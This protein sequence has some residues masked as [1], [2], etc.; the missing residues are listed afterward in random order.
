MKR[1]ILLTSPLLLLLPA[2]A[3]EKRGENFV[4]GGRNWS[5]TLDARGSILS[6]HGASSKA[7]LWK[8]G[9]A[10]LWSARLRDASVVR[11][12][13]AAEVTSSLTADHKTLTLKY[14]QPALDVEVTATERADG[15]DWRA[16]VSP[17]TQAL[18]EFAL[19]ARLRFDSESMLRLVTPAQ[20][21]EA[22]GLA[23]KP[24]FFMRQSAS[25]AAGW[26][27][28]TAGP[29]AY[30]AILGAPPVQRDLAEAA[31]ALS[32]APAASQWLSPDAAQ[33]LAGKTARVVR[34]M[35]RA[36]ADVVLIDSANG[37]YLSGSK[38]G[39]SGGLLW[40][41]G[42]TVETADEW[43]APIIAGLIA[44]IAGNATASTS[45][46][47][48]PRIAMLSLRRGPQRG[49]F[50]GVS[51]DQWRAQLRAISSV[52]LEE[53]AD[54][55]SL[56]RA[57]S[58]HQYAAI[59]NPYGEAI[60]TGDNQTPLDVATQIAAWV[61]GGGHWIET[62]GFS[63]FK[64]L[65]P[66]KYFS[67]SAPYPG[68]FA[69]FF[70]LDGNGSSGALYSVQPQRET[71]WKAL[72]NPALALVP[73]RWSTGG[74]DAGAYLE[75]AWTP[76]VEPGTSWT[77]PISRL[78][79]GGS[80]LENA[81]R[82]ALDNQITRTLSDKMAPALLERFKRAVLVYYAG[83]A[84]S[85]IA[86]LKYLPPGCALHFA[87]YLHGGF[88]KQLPDHLPPNAGFGTSEQLAQF[89][90]QARRSG[91][92][93]EPYT[94]PTWWCDHPPGPTFLREGRAPLQ[95]NEDKSNTHE[96][97]SQND[98]WSI[99]LWHPSV[100]AAN[101]VIR[102]QFTQEFPVDV[103]FQDQVGARSPRLDFNP[104]SPS[105]HAYM[106]GLLAQAQEDSQVVPLSTENG[107]DH[108]VNWESQMCGFTFGTVPTEDAPA[109]STLLRDRFAPD[110][111]EVFPL[112]QAMA[113]DKV[114]FIHHDLGQFVTNREVLAW[115]LALGF[116]MSLRTDAGALGSDGPREWLKYLDRV[117]KSVCARMMGAP[118]QSWEYLNRDTIAS[119]FGD[120]SVQ[121]AL[122]PGAISWSAR[123][124]QVLA[125][126]D[127]KSA[128][129]IAQRRADGKFDVWFYGA[130]QSSARLQ[131]P[132][133]VG[134]S[135]LRWD[136]EKSSAALK[137][138]AVALTLP[139][140][141]NGRVQPPRELNMAPKQW[142][143]KPKIGLIEMAG[144][145]TPWSEITPAQWKS[146]LDQSRLAKQFGL[147]VE[148]LST[149]AQVLEALAG[150][151]A[152]YFAI[153]NPHTE[154]FPE[155]GRDRWREML[156]SIKSYVEHGGQWWATGGYSFFSAAWLE[157]GKWQQQDVG[158]SGLSTFGIP[159][160][161]GG[162]EDAPQPLRVE[163]EGS[164]WL[165]KGLQAKIAGGTSVINRGL[166]RSSEEA[167]HIALVGGA[168]GD[169]IGAYRL[170]GWGGLWRIGGFHPNPELAPQVVTEALEYQWTHAPE[171]VKISTKYLWHAVVEA[172]GVAKAR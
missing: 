62:G 24:A 82:H 115:T 9:A 29:S 151:P 70:H 57:L 87:D 59:L 120:V 148:V 116:N 128:P 67:Y 109:W 131:L 36:Q 147:Q 23:L 66:V 98:G 119:R 11:A 53:I 127:G 69:H 154:I 14:L 112:A 172:Q 97:Y 110:T 79:F 6:S 162:I 125:L 77:A 165:S 95:V 15:V 96:S 167:G 33:V 152:K 135:S 8:S 138:G 40:R 113:H 132:A 21:H 5:L 168:S 78:L 50:A 122:K 126:D 65:R 16:Q 55:P 7:T 88:D 121:A 39:G 86:N 12:V 42:G 32:L 41:I 81:R 73:S 60:P 139:T 118:L 117:Q 142:K 34:P 71:G 91:Q 129:S 153:V 61:R 18:T 133:S 141:A 19:P 130:P 30:S 144:L 45:A 35:T 68:S 140:R 47:G 2:R 52:K 49:D 107:W 146:A 136:E 75:A 54:L 103:L 105:P 102:D 10:G 20:V 44:K 84:G 58:S 63:F 94:N 171:P 114:A 43:N 169:W 108:L 28:E 46:G 90:A 143:A 158:D 38:L 1:L 163:G 99:T 92:L 89:F 51:V 155:A 111:F 76:W 72:Q 170:N 22:P 106:A 85:K 159:I 156:G 164:S 161:S 134:A 157:D 31:V 48:A 26:Q 3:I 27:Q 56:E 64:A 149:P 17:K 104:A 137:P 13:D 37:P 124:P 101:K 83:D 160:G 80:A 123:A 93:I 166:P 25:S 150:G 100:R 4:L 74:D 145:G